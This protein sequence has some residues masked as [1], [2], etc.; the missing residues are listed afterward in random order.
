MFLKLMRAKIHCAKVTATDVD[1]V[2][3]ITIDADLLDASGIL[4]NEC[5]LVADLDNGSRHWT[6]AIAGPRGSGTICINGA[7]AHLVNVGDRV[8]VICFGYCS[9]QEAG[10]LEPKVILVDERNR[11]VCR[12]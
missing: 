12:P 5:V 1:Y 9:P 2:G 7:A 4:P 6:Y 8:I 10:G 11:P 3:S